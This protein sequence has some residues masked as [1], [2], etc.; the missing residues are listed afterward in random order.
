MAAHIKGA[1]PLSNDVKY[2]ADINF[3]GKVNVAD[4]SLTAARIKGKDTGNVFISVNRDGIIKTDKVDVMPVYAYWGSDGTLHVK[5]LVTSGCKNDISQLY[6]TVSV[7]SGNEPIAQ[8]IFPDNVLRN[9]GALSYGHSVDYELIFGKF[10]VLAY[11][12]D[13]TKDMD[14]S[15]TYSFK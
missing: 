10:D 8:G 4:L 9:S 15:M 6:L 1:K 14:L 11:N 3:D 13:I 2:C 5:T 12:S 7:F